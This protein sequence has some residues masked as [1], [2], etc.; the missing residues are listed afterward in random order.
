MKRIILIV[1][2]FLVSCE[3]PSDRPTDNQSHNTTENP[4]YRVIVDGKE[5]I[6]TEYKTCRT[7]WG[8]EHILVYCWRQLDILGESLTNADYVFEAESFEEIIK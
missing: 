8:G 6:I 7:K 5:R 4:S 3:S 2:L 1:F